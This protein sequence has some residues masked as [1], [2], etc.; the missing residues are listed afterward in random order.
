MAQLTSDNSPLISGPLTQSQMSWIG[1]INCVGGLLG[2]LVSCYI[3]SLVGAKRASLYLAIP[4][5]ACH[6]LI[7]FGNT[8]V[9]IVVARFLGGLGAGGVDC[10]VT[11]FISEI[12]ND[13]YV[14]LQ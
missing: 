5:V 14:Y 12:S 2:S 10:T 4:F 7:Y 11:L 3:I 1:S 8:F 9:H 6:L 13:K